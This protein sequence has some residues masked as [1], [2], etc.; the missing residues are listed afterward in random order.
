MGIAVIRE[1]IR[2]P[3]AATR[4][5]CFDE[6]ICIESALFGFVATKPKSLCKF[7]RKTFFRHVRN[8]ADQVSRF[9]FCERFSVGGAQTLEAV[10]AT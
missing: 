1:R 8:D 10:S 6:A 5:G 4:I 9:R 2:L 7:E 3:R